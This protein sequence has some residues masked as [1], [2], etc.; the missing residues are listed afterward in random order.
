MRELVG[1]KYDG[2]RYKAKD[3]LKLDKTKMTFEIN[4]DVLTKLHD[5]EVRIT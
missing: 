4:P 5:I 3:R 1:M 2:K